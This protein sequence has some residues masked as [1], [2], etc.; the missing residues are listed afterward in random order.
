MKDKNEN[1]E[2]LG[3]R[4]EARWILCVCLEREQEVKHVITSPQATRYRN[5]SD[6]EMPPIPKC[7]SRYCFFEPF[8]FFCVHLSLHQELLLK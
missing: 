3:L 5:A 4:N 8:G 7:F 2:K 1:K 6:P